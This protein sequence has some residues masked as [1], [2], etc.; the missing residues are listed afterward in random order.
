[1]VQLS[2]RTT[3]EGFAARMNRRNIAK[4]EILEEYLMIRKTL[5]GAMI[6]GGFAV[7]VQAQPPMKFGGGILQLDSDGD[8]RV[9]RVEFQ[10]P[11]HRRGGPFERADSDGDGTVSRDDLVA[12]IDES[13]DEREQRMRER[14]IQRFDEADADGNGVVTQEE[15]ENLAFSRADA[16]GDGFVTE[17][18]V[19]A[20]HANRKSMRG[21]RPRPDGA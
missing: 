18:E 2:L 17:E 16:D 21:A 15:R 19:E 12:A 3:E 1:M 13:A 8:G 14:A 7:A 4:D 10:P 11:Q 6:I 5:M 9:S 20:M